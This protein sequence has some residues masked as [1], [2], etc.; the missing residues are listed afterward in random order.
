MTAEAEP[1]ASEPPRLE[2]PVQFRAQPVFPKAW[3]TRKILR[4][5]I[6]FP[7]SA[8]VSLSRFSWSSKARL[9]CCLLISS[10]VSAFPHP[11]LAT[12]RRAKR[13]SSPCAQGLESTLRRRLPSSFSPLALASEIYAVRVK[14]SFLPLAWMTSVSARAIRRPNFLP[15]GPG[16][17]A[18]SS[19][20]R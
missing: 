5:S 14:D 4:R 3:A 10:L 13:L 20:R 12:F 6:A 2:R 15:V 17:M 8:K 1:P 16:A 11:N 7:V 18:C 19:L 9:P